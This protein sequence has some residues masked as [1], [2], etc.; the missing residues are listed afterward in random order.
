[1]TGDPEFGLWVA[2]VAD[3]LE[4]E[5]G[6]TDYDVAA[7]YA[8]NLLRMYPDLLAMA[9]QFQNGDAGREWLVDAVATAVQLSADDFR[10]PTCGL[11]LE[12]RGSF[13][14]RLPSSG[15]V[16]GHQGFGETYLCESGHWWTWIQGKLIG[17]ERILTVIERET[18]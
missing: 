16:D 1:V 3:V 15:V 9:S 4:A 10:C 13:D 2:H 5:H 18:P 7:D 12:R 14:G 11:P 6:A 17:P 8:V